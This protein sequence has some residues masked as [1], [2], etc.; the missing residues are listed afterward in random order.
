MKILEKKM[1]RKTKQIKK[2]QKR[3]AHRGAWIR[4]GKEPCGAATFFPRST[5]A[6]HAYERGN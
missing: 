6:L 2:R 4:A 5:V 3:I 1:P